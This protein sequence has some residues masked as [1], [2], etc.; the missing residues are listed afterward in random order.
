[1]TIELEELKKVNLKSGDVVVWSLTEHIT[2]LGKDALFP[3]LQEMFPDNKF[4]FLNPGETLQVV[5]KEKT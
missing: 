4:I 3:Q 5:S 2:K 1:M